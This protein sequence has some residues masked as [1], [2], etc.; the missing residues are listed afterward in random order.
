MK[1]YATIKA[2]KLVDGQI[3]EVSKSQGSNK[4]LNMEIMGEDRQILA[5]MIVMTSK[6]SDGKEGYGITL[7]AQKR[8]FSEWIPKEETKGNKQKGKC[9]CPSVDCPQH[10]IDLD[11]L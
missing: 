8:G 11:N 4:Y 10:A 6:S 7:T 5:N 2:G 3:M 1:L 9:E